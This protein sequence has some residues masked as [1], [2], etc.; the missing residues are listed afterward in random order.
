MAFIFLITV[1]KRWNTSMNSFV[2]PLVE[3]LYCLGFFTFSAVLFLGECLSYSKHK[4]TQPLLHAVIAAVLSQ[5][6]RLRL[7]VIQVVSDSCWPGLSPRKCC[8]QCLDCQAEL[9][10]SLKV[11]SIARLKRYCLEHIQPVKKQ[12]TGCWC[13]AMMILDF[14][15]NSVC[16][17]FELF[18][19]DWQNF[20]DMH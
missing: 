1:E 14:L 3:S 20:V 18:K 7:R 19:K 9:N 15:Q 4:F 17:N 10:Q 16:C 12:F 8:C 11:S 6:Y 2:K 13:Q 5:L